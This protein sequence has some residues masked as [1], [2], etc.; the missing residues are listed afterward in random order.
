MVASAGASP[1][2]IA[3]VQA[4]NESKGLEPVVA[5]RIAV[6]RLR[7]ISLEDFSVTHEFSMVWERGSAF[8]STYRLICEQLREGR[9]WGR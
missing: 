3:Q 9:A 2:E 7:E 1:E 5:E 8:E 4:Y 6:G